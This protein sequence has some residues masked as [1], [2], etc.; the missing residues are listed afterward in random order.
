MRTFAELFNV[1]SETTVL[2]IGGSPSIWEG[3]HPRPNL[4]LVNTV[5]DWPHD[6]FKVL[7]GDAVDLP[8]ASNSFDIAFSNSVI[9]HLG[10]WERQQRMAREI[11]RVAKHYFVQTPNFWFPIETHY[12][13]PCVH[14]LPR[15]WRPA[16]VR[17]LSPHVRIAKFSREQ[18]TTMVEEISLL[19]EKQ[20]RC[21]FPEG[22]ILREKICGL[23]KSIVAYK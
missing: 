19:T 10:T 9:E 4:M 11:R 12:W 2:D 14:Y 21:L 17:W 1:T 16:V 13:I 18:V 23:T 8:F 5:M 20:M 3:Y 15:S 22:T 6:G 7:W